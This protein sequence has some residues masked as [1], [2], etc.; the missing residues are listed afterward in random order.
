MVHIEKNGYGS[1]AIFERFVQNGVVQCANLLYRQLICKALGKLRLSHLSL[2]QLE[3]PEIADLLD[4]V[5]GLPFM[6]RRSGD[7][8]RLPAA[9]VSPCTYIIPDNT[10]FSSE[11]TLQQA[12][13]DDG[14]GDPWI[15]AEVIRMAPRNGSSLLGRLAGLRGRKCS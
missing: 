15:F 6:E 13:I 8:I 5:V 7:A 3:Y 1:I 9:V 2:D 14:C 11:P 12:L 10:E 4:L